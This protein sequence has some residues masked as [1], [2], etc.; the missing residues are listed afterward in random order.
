MQSYFST[1]FANE[2]IAKNPLVIV[3]FKEKAADKESE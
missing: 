3:F 2:D 1:F